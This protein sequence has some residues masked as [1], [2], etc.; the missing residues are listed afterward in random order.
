MKISNDDQRA[1]GL[2]LFC[3]AVLCFL[4]GIAGH[5][6]SEYHHRGEISCTGFTIA[7][8]LAAA[9]VVMFLVSLKKKRG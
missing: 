6:K 9:G 5:F 7:I 4:I 1:I 2:I 8:I 3:V